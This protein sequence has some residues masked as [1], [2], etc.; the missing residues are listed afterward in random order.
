MN[1]IVYLIPWSYNEKES[2]DR[3]GVTWCVCGFIVFA[4][5]IIY[6]KYRLNEG[7]PPWGATCKY[8]NMKFQRFKICVL[9]WFYLIMIFLSNCWAVTCFVSLCIGNNWYLVMF[10]FFFINPGLN[11]VHIFY[12]SPGCF[13]ICCLTSSVFT[14]SRSLSMDT[15]SKFHTGIPEKAQRTIT[16]NRL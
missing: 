13:W 16:F 3:C 10:F 2:T 9:T 15:E 1:K 11:S 5:V 14:E 7:A 8:C 6:V 4:A 12:L